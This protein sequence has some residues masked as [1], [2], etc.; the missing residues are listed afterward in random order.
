MEKADRDGLYLQAVVESGNAAEDT[1]PGATTRSAVASIPARHYGIILF[2][3]VNVY[4]IWGVS[5]PTSSV[6]ALDV[7]DQTVAPFRITAGLVIALVPLAVSL[8]ATAAPRLF[9]SVERTLFPLA[10]ACSVAG[11]LALV[12]AATAVPAPALFGAA[13]VLVGIGNACCFLLWGLVLTAMD[14]PA[15]TFV[16]LLS[17]VVSGAANLALFSL[18]TSVAY[19]AIAFVLAVSLFWLKAS[20]KDVETPRAPEGSP[21]RIHAPSTMPAASGQLSARKQLACIIRGIGSPLLCVVALGLVFNAFRETAF[22]DVGRTAPVNIVSMAALIVGTGTVLAILGLRKT[23]P[24]AIDG[25]YPYAAAVVAA[26]LIALPFTGTGYSMLLVFITSGVYLLSD[27]LLKNTMARA[28]RHARAEIH[29]LAFFGLGLGAIFS[30]MAAGSILGALP[31]AGGSA[32]QVMY[33]VALVLVCVYL[34][35]LPLIGLRRKPVR[36][37]IV[38]RSLDGDE[39]RARCARVAQQHGITQ[40]ERA[41]LEQLALG[42]TVAAISKDLGLSENTVRSYSKALYRKLGVHSKQELINLIGQ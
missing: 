27:T 16:L 42:R 2:L 11:Y 30:T 8:L 38:I 7:Y 29:P 6:I 22:A 15:S 33:V 39:L 12:A 20:L 34:L 24:P 10:A 9:A 4:I 17:G 35:M 13:G 1:V 40:G 28:A 25:L 23:K 32:N 37:G 41:V 5:L 36:D 19:P 26:C 31:R 14:E 18:P 3:V 21:A